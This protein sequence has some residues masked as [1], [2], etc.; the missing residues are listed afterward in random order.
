MI[1]VYPGAAIHGKDV[2]Q[3]IVEA[4]FFIFM[5]IVALAGLYISV[6]VAGGGFVLL[7]IWSLLH[8]LF[9]IGVNCG[10]PF[11]LGFFTVNMIMALFIILFLA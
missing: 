10:R 2:K 8:Y 9:R 1:A 5:F 3:I 6:L 11:A 4:I 7:G